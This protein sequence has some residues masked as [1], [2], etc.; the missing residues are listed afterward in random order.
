M[1]KQPTVNGGRQPLLFVVVIRGRLRHHRLRCC[2]CP[3]PG[4]TPTAERRTDNATAQRQRGWLTGQQPQLMLPPLP[5]SREVEGE[6]PAAGGGGARQVLLRHRVV[7]VSAVRGCCAVERGIPQIGVSLTIAGR[8]VMTKRVAD[9]ANNN[10]PLH[11]EGGRA[12]AC[13][14]S[15][16]QQNGEGQC[17]CR[18]G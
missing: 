12:A 6:L 11:I 7:V 9:R 3:Y 15:S 4:W 14:K 10:Q 18:R 17:R 8:L 13:K 1:T 5:R 2:C 16:G